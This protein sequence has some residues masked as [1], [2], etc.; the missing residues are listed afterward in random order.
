MGLLNKKNIIRVIV[1]P[2]LLLTIACGNAYNDLLNQKKTPV[3]FQLSTTSYPQPGNDGKVFSNG[4]VLNWTKAIS[5]EKAANEYKYRVYYS[6]SDNIKSVQTMIQNGLPASEWM[7]GIELLDVTNLNLDINQTY[8]FNVMVMNALG[9][10]SAYQGCSIFIVPCYYDHDAPEITTPKSGKVYKEL[11]YYYPIVAVN[12][13]L[14]I[15]DKNFI[16]VSN[17]IQKSDNTWQVT[18]S[19]SGLYNGIKYT[20]KIT[21]TDDCG[22]ASEIKIIYLKSSGCSKYG[23]IPVC[24]TA[25]F[26]SFSIE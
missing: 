11:Y 5:I 13:K 10:Q 18:I 17:A 20:R 6:Q 9:N 12:I 16:T 22:N 8:Y 2:F 25:L 26:Y 23:I 15:I 24:S 14:N 19:S 1:F 4:L 3:L 21:A 7:E